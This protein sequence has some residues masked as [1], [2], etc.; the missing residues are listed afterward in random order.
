[1]QNNWVNFSKVAF[2]PY[3]RFFRSSKECH[4]PSGPMVNTPMPLIH[5]RHMALYMYKRFSTDRQFRE[6]NSSLD[7]QPREDLKRTNSHTLPADRAPTLVMS[8][9]GTGVE[10]SQRHAAGPSGNRETTAS[11]ELNLVH[12]SLQ[13]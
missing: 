5:L 2:L 6:K 10:T 8:L 7:D 3:T 12:Y 4:G 1:M 13:Y 11:H 9:Q